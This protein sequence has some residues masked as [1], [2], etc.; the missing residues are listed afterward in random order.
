MDV[1]WQRLFDYLA[2]L[3]LYRCGLFYNQLKQFCLINYLTVNLVAHFASSMGIKPGKCRKS[4]MEMLV[5]LR[6]MAVAVLL[7]QGSA[8][9]S[10]GGDL[11][12][13]ITLLFYQW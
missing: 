2:D 7:A 3:D 9:S 8:M 6:A 13:S 10:H 4:I 1:D 12:H 11:D 5:T